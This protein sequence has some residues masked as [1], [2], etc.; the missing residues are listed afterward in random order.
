MKHHIHRGSYLSLFALNEIYMYAN[1]DQFKYRKFDD[2]LISP[3]F[4]CLD[5][6]INYDSA[7]IN[8]NG[9]VLNKKF[10]LKLLRKLGKEKLS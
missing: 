9:L 8:K 10:L 6:T 1:I 2:I 3:N 7:T 4:S 5:E